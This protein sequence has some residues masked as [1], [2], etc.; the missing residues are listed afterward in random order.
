M[1]WPTLSLDRGNLW[2]PRAPTK[3]GGADFYSASAVPHHTKYRSKCL[4]KQ[5]HTTGACFHVSPRCDLRGW[6]GVHDQWSIYLCFHHSGTCSHSTA[7]I[8]SLLPAVM[9]LPFVFI[10]YSLPIHTNKQLNSLYF[11]SR[12][13]VKLPAVRLCF[14]FLG[15]FFLL[16]F[17]KPAGDTQEMT[18]YSK[19]RKKGKKLYK[20]INASKCIIMFLRLLCS[21]ASHTNSNQKWQRQKLNW[22]PI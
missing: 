4:C 20:K 3:V 5:C 11:V 7:F 15:C 16:F 8:H 17:S 12:D 19:R 6:L 2:Q 21:H 22:T 9:A 18:E 14:G 13:Q 1:F 10:H